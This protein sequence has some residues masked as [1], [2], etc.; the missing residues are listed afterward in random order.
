M[1]AGV[2]DE[3]CDEASDAP[4][5]TPVTSAP[6]ESPTET[7][8]TSAPTDAPTEEATVVECA[9][10]QSNEEELQIPEFMQVES[11]E[12]TNWISSYTINPPQDSSSSAIPHPGRVIKMAIFYGSYATYD[13][14]IRQAFGDTSKYSYVKY[15]A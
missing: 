8:V 2:A 12:G 5:E 6:T 11:S 13:S 4:T 15:G 3:A 9:C 1:A 10:Q 7:P 14:V